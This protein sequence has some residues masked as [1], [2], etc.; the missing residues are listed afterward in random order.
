MDKPEII[1]RL[2]REHGGP[3]L[4]GVWVAAGKQHGVCGVNEEN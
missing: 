3:P 4:H 2:V 1:E